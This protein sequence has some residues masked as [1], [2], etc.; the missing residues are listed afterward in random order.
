MKRILPFAIV[1]AVIVFV[2]SCSK[3]SD[4]NY[5]DPCGGSAP[6]GLVSLLISTDQDIQMGQQTRDYVESDSSGMKILDS[7]KNVAAYANIY[8]I[9][10]TILNSGKVY[11]KDVFPW[12][13]RIIKDD[14]TLNAFC[15]PGGFIYV[16]SGIIKYLDNETELA[17]VMGHEMAHADRR[18]SAKAMIEQY[19]LVSLISIL[20]GGNPGQIA[21]LS[22]NLILLKYSRDHETEADDYSVRFLYPTVYDPRGAKYFFEKIGSQGVPAF[23]STHPDP[24]NRVTDITTKWT[25]LGGRTDGQTFDARYAQFK[26]LLP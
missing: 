6:G 15:T 16:Y 23:L 7:A 20:T 25:C 1:I 14:S 3:S 22:A 24:G 2:A 17:G 13:V 4:S 12:R 10:D 8:R 5:S 26:A 18:H 21:S 11:Y 19:G 9:R